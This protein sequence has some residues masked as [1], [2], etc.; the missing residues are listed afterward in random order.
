MNTPITIPWN[1]KK[2]VHNLGASLLPE[3]LMAM[4]LECIHYQKQAATERY[5]EYQPDERAAEAVS[6]AALG[7]VLARGEDVHGIATDRS[8]SN[9]IPFN[10]TKYQD[11]VNDQRLRELRKQIDLRIGDTFQQL[12]TDVPGKLKVVQS[13]HFWYP[14]GSFMGWH[15]NS[16]VPGWRAYLS[17]TEAPG[18]SFFRYRDTDSEGIVTLPDQGWD[19][20]VFRLGAEN[21]LWHAVYSNTNRFSFGYMLTSESLTKRVE[22]RVRQMFKGN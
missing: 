21:P 4:A 6:E 16:R 19:L 13:G 1:T 15:T 9:V 8:I 17:Y 7:S 10:V 11:A 3:D 5:A 20:R 22:R 14:S 2:P 18:E 12:F